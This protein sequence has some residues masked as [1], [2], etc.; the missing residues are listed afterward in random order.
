M[1]IQSIETFLQVASLE[2]YTRAAEKLNFA[3][4]TVTMQ[5]QRLEQEL[6]YPLFERIGRRNYLTAA[7]K[8]F[9]PH[10]AEILRLMQKV[11]GLG[12]KPQEIRGTLRIGVLESLFFAVILKVLP[13]LGRRFPKVNVEIKLG[14]ASQMLLMLK[15]NQIDL[16]YISHDLVGDPAFCCCYRCREEISFIASPQHPFAKKT[17]I[18]PEEM[19]SV[20]FI[21]AEP[22]GRCYERLH[23]IAADYNITLYHSIVVDNIRAIVELLQDSRSASFLPRYSVSN[24]IEKKKIS[25]LDVDLAPQIY[26][27]QVIYHRDKWLSQYM[28]CF[29]ELVRRARPEVLD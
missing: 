13:E 7:G 10:A 3:Q 2:N 18:P 11:S 1:D 5:I 12:Q 24:F 15:Q 9:L 21:V 27:S 8:T 4:S 17:A 25:V 14:Q 26:Y 29:I 6:G 20:P 16:A 19:L 28:E 22:S 23:E